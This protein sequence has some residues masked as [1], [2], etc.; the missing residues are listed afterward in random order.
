LEESIANEHQSLVFSQWTGLL[1]L[2]GARLSKQGIAYLRIDGST[3]NRQE[4]VAQFQG[5]KQAPVLLLSLKAAGVGLNLT[6]ADHVYIMDPWW[7]PAVEDQAADRAHRIGQRNP[8][9]VHRLVSKNTV[10][11][12][13]L[14]LQA[15]KKDL[16][17]AIVGAP[18]LGG[19]ISREELLALV[20]E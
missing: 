13:I 9:L 8:V 4:I 16:A 7:N 14:Q 2:I 20:E 3:K 1:D 15:S 10:E 12:K 6:A 19:G 5:S 17:Q 18:G 11:E